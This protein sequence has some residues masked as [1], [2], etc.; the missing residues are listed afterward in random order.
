MRSNCWPWWVIVLLAAQVRPGHGGDAAQTVRYLRAADHGF[1]TE[2]NRVWVVATCRLLHT[3]PRSGKTAVAVVFSPDGTNLH[4][5][6]SEDGVIVAVEAATGRWHDLGVYGSGLQRLA[7]APDARVL[8]A[9]GDSGVRT[10]A[11]PDGAPRSGLVDAPRSLRTVAF[12]PDA[13]TLALGGQDLVRL[14][15]VATGRQ[16]STAGFPATV[17]WI[18]FRPGGST[19]A[20]LGEAPGSH[21]LV[22]DA[23]T[24]AQSLRLESSAVQL[25]CGAWRADGE[26]LT[27]VGATNSTVQL[28]DFSHVPPKRHAVTASAARI[29]GIDAVAFSP[30]GRHLVTGNADGTIAI[31]RLARKGEV[32]RAP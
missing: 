10:W 9:A 28:W 2:S 22:S 8:A 17:R 20:A 13:R 27:T 26:L 11:L 30:E 12:S 25:V 19:L 32:F 3:I 15:D 24:G 7:I 6:W 18:G 31:L 23:A 14:F 5:G 16:A 21:V 4:A 1:A 29:Q